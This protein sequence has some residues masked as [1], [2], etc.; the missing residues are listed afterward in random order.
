MGGSR[1]HGYVLVILMR[2]QNL[3]KKVEGDLRLYMQMKNF[4]DVC[5]G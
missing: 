3:M 2:L 5:F 1:Y 4:S